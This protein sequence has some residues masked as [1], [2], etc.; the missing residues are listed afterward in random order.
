MSIVKDLTNMRFGSLI[1]IHRNG[2]TKRGLA[3]WSCKCDC[4]NI[5]DFISSNLLNGHSTRCK[6]CAIKSSVKK[7]T[8]ARRTP[9]SDDIKT[10]IVNEYCTGETPTSLSKKYHRSYSTI[11]GWLCQWGVKKPHIFMSKSGYSTAFNMVY[12]RYKNSAKYRKLEFDI[13]KTDFYN[14]TQQKCF[15]CGSNPNNKTVTATSEYTYNG[16]DRKDNAIGYIKNN[17]VVCCGI[18]NRAKHTLSIG[19]FEQWIN[20]L[21][22]FRAN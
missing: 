14:L 12:K 6:I 18:C 5:Q 2:S 11:V 3:K 9:V 8:G 20:N 7:R 13:S 19:D 16:I 10:Q 15:Y 4:G 17:I 21:I 22:S 1:V